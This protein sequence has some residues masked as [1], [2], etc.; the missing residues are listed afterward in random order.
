MTS[1]Q[2]AAFS[3]RAAATGFALWP[4]VVLIAGVEYA[5]TITQPSNAAAEYVEGSEMQEGTLVARVAMAILP[6]APATYQSLKWKRPGATA[7]HT[8]TW[9]IQ[10]VTGTPADAEW[11]IVCTPKN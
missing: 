9:F 3:T 11:R 8:V 4:A 1:T 7:W 2:L 5:A 6:A 10:E